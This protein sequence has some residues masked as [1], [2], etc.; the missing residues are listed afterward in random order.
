MYLFFYSKDYGS[1]D[2]KM[3]AFWLNNALLN[4]ATT[5]LL[6]WWTCS[7][8]SAK[9]ECSLFFFFLLKKILFFDVLRLK[10]CEG[11]SGFDTNRFH[12]FF[13]VVAHFHGFSR[14][15]TLLHH[16]QF[17]YYVPGV[18]KKAQLNI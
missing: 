7:L 6:I 9:K 2:F 12:N 11:F 17:T 4:F 13:Q 8:V 18:H 16:W 14:F 3:F 10:F 1:F 15:L 5:F